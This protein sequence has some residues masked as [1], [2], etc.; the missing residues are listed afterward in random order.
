M[1]AAEKWAQLVARGCKCGGID[2]PADC[3][4]HHGSDMRGIAAYF[5]AG[6]PLGFPLLA[7]CA[8]CSADSLMYP[9]IPLDAGHLLAGEAPP[10]TL[11]CP[12]CSAPAAER[13]LR[14]E[15]EA[16]GYVLNDRVVFGLA[17]AA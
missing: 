12:R 10:P 5:A 16:F 1:S 17:V 8:I 6:M 7:N 9:S 4:L 11:V 2:N 13:A 15:A 14:E 3:A